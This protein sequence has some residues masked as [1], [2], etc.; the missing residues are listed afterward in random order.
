[1]I[2]RSIL[3]YIQ[4]FLVGFLLVD[5]FLL[6]WR[7]SIPSSNAWWDAIWLAC[8]VPV[9]LV[10]RFESLS[11]IVL[12][13]V[14]FL[15]FIACFRGRV[16]HRIVTDPWV[17]TIGGMCYS[18]YLVHY[19]VLI[20]VSRAFHGFAVPGGYLPSVLAL[21]AVWLLAIM[22]VSV[23]YFVFFERPFMDRHWPERLAARFH[24]PPT[25]LPEEPQLLGND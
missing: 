16:V 6:D 3:G 14:F 22:F 13:G 17:F 20:L 21:S 2:T 24:Q 4:F 7:G 8:W 12:P 18:I 5:I 9:A 15:L 23:L 19:G 25:A 11:E 1:V 10:Q